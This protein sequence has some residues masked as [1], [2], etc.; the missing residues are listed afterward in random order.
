MKRLYFLVPDVKHTR[1]IVNELLLARISIE[2]IH[3]MAREGTEMSDLPK[4]TLAQRSDVIP[5]FQKGIIMGGLAAFVVGGLIVSFSP[6]GPF[7]GWGPVFGLSLAGVILGAVAATLIGVKSPSTRIKRFEKAI[8]RGKLLLM[9]DVPK[10]RR[11]EIEE[12]IRSHYPEARV[13]DADPHMPA[14]S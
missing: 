12:L 4:A 13:M 8:R 9:V 11:R 10:E 1:I 7:L 3:V 6:A 5:A 2:H 14:F